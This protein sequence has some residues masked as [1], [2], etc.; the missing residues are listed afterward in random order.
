MQDEIARRISAAWPDAQVEVQIDGNR[1]L[2]VVTSGHFDGLSRVARQQAVYAFVEDM[3]A[4][5]R[6]HA[7]TIRASVPNA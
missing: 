4:D 5:G 6:L 1:A 3:I 7:V 2:I